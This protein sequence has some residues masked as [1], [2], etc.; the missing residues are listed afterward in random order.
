MIVDDREQRVPE[1]V[2]AVDDARGE[3]FRA[4]G[5]DVVLVLDVEHGGARDAGDDRERDRAERDRGQD[6][7]LDRVPERAAVARR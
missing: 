7:M 3:P 1:D 5:A 6:Q 4:G 2:P